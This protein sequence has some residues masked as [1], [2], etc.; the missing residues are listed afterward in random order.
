MSLC[1]SNSPMR[2]IAS[3]ALKTNIALGY[4]RRETNQVGSELMLKTTR[5][6]ERAMVMRE[7]KSYLTLTTRPGPD[8]R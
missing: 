8:P 4:V 1:A 3:P 7:L 5:G 6:E 2:A